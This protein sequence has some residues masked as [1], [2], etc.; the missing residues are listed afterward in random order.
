[1]DNG[2]SCGLEV[3][4]LWLNF[5]IA[6]VEAHSSFLYFS[7]ALQLFVRVYYLIFSLYLF[8]FFFRYFQ[9]QI[10]TV[11]LFTPHCGTLRC[12]TRRLMRILNSVWPPGRNAEIYTDFPRAGA[13]FWANLIRLKRQIF[14]F[15]SPFCRRGKYMQ[16]LQMWYEACATRATEPPLTS[17]CTWTRHSIAAVVVVDHLSGS[18]VINKFLL[19]LALPL[20]LSLPLLLALRRLEQNACKVGNNS[21]TTNLLWFHFRFL[22]VLFIVAL[23]FLS[24]LCFHSLF[25][26]W[27]EVNLIW[28]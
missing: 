14:V 20:P 5:C 19:P 13:G 18:S 3:K 2:V 11:A 28:F 10:N 4:I 21:I 16:T 25:L 24:S 1:M 17:P 26:L 27:I 15:V 9:Q 8:F 12:V 22:L 23:L 7:H 6:H